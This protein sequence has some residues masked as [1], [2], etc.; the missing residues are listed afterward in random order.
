MDYEYAFMASTI[1]P[2]PGIEQARSAEASRS[3]GLALGQFGRTITGAIPDFMG[4]G[5]EA[6]SHDLTKIE[7]HLVVTVCLRRPK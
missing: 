7:Q 2:E 4:G 6:I 1:T 3:I 5:W